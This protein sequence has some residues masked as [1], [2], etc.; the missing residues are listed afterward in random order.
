MQS[1]ETLPGTVEPGPGMKLARTRKATGPSLKSTLA[2]W[3][4][5]SGI[6]RD[7]KSIFRAIIFRMDWEG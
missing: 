4:W 3:I 2:G 5:D 7:E 6:G 1:L